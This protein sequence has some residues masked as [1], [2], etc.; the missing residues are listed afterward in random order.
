M[1]TSTKTYGHTEGLSVCF[2]QHSSNS[3]CRFLHG[4]ALSFK[5]TFAAD[6]LDH[7]GWVQDFGGLR[8]LKEALV[9]RFD[10][11]LLV[12]EDDPYLDEL[13][14]FSGL[15]IADVHVVPRVGCEAF[16]K[17]GFDIAEEVTDKRVK[18]V[19]CEV[20]EHGANSAIYWG[21]KNEADDHK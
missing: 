11:T 20:S 10:H 8:K 16:A 13:C 7:C 14:T 19:S 18:V 4:Y 6:E 21:A 1:Y 3:H 5:F 17:M 12:A 2:R 9:R 15:G